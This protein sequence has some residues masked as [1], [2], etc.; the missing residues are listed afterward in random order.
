M[1]ETN[2]VQEKLVRLTAN[3]RKFKIYVHMD[4]EDVSEEQLI[5]W[6]F[7]SQTIAMQRVLRECSAQTL[8]EFEE[9]GYEVHALHAGIKPRTQRQIMDEA[10]TAVAGLT[11]IQKA[12]LLE[13]LMA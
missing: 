7:Q 6:A 5:K 3:N 12:E 13:Q 2:L 9:S 1:S 8:E 11:D 10:K 4:F